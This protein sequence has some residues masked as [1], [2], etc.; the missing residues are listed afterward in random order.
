MS[1]ADERLHLVGRLDVSRR[2]TWTTH[3]DS[4]ATHG[5]RNGSSSSHICRNRWGCLQSLRVQA[6]HTGC[7]VD[8]SLTDD[9]TLIGNFLRGC[10]GVNSRMLPGDVGFVENTLKASLSKSMWDTRVTTG[11]YHERDRGQFFFMDVI[12]ARHNRIDGRANDALH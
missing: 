6:I 7:T 12:M 8:V 9:I 11:A 1:T 10:H 5:A 3:G 2:T 4:W